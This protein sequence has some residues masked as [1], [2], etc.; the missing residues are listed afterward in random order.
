MINPRVPI[1][2]VITPVFNREKTIGRAIKSLQ[3]QTF[4]EYEHIIINDVSTDST[5]QIVK[6]YQNN[7]Y[8]IKY[9]RLDYNKTDDCYGAAKA[10]NV[11]IK[12][13]KG[14]Y[15]AFLD[16]DDTFEPTKLEKQLSLFNRLPQSYSMIYSGFNY[17]AEDKPSTKYMLLPS[18]KGDLSHE[19]LYSNIAGTLQPLVKRSAVI[20]AGLFDEKMPSCQD[21]DLWIRV[22]RCG[23]FDFVP[24]A[25]SN[26]YI[27]GNQISS[28]TVKKLEARER[29][30]N[31]YKKQI[32][33]DPRIN[34]KHLG[35]MGSLSA[36]VGKT[37]KARKYYWASLTVNP[38]Q[39]GVCFHLLFSVL[40]PRAHQSH[41]TTRKLK[42]YG[43]I[44]IAG[45]A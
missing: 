11:G 36:I 37:H 10:R 25:L 27:H 41:L 19:I 5:E 39:P 15:L 26:A 38:F 29:I 4:Q 23:K 2:S 20:K 33:E 31:K 12:Q 17:V 1:V 30:Y 28:S 34:T 22:A 6:E 32:V 24:E 13:A 9:I 42:K 21:W 3:A 40:S 43:N 44:T 45:F 14:K 8:R 35:V 16:S 7:D 18:K